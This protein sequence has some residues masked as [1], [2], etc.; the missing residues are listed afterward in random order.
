MLFRAP[1][2]RGAGFY[3]TGLWGC[4][5]DLDHVNLLVTG[6]LAVGEGQD[7]FGRDLFVAVAQGAVSSGAFQ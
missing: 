1:L 3:R 6:Q 7:F 5:D 2:V 4:V